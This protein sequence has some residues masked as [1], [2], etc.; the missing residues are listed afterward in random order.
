[1][2]IIR[3]YQFVEEQD[4]G[5]SVAIGNFDGVHRGHQSVIDLARAAAPEAP[6]GVMTFEPHPRA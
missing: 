3:D 2:R 4:R 6:L 1:M 5:A